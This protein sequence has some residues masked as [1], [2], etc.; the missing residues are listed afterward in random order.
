MSNAPTRGCRVL[1]RALPLK[2]EQTSLRGLAIRVRK[3]IAKLLVRVNHRKISQSRAFQGYRSWLALRSFR[4]CLPNG[5]QG[6]DL[7]EGFEED[8][9]RPGFAHH[10]PGLFVITSAHQNCRQVLS[11]LGQT[12]T[13]FDSTHPGQIDVGQKAHVITSWN[14]AGEQPLSSVK[15]NTL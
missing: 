13:D 10:P 7:V 6:G 11:C 8:R 15:T 1:S 14:R 9:D 5:A 3:F 2:R 4:N 12:S